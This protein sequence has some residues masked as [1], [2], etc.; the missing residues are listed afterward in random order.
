MFLSRLFGKQTPAPTNAVRGTVEIGIAAQSDPS[1]PEMRIVVGMAT[2][3]GC[4]REINED[5]VDVIRPDSAEALRDIGVVAV[6]CDG[7]GGHEGG[8]V[9]SRLAIEAF[10]RQVTSGPMSP[11]DMLI[12]AISA[13]NTA[14]ISAARR[15]P[16]LTGMG[17]TC[18]A[19]LLREGLAHC[20]HVGDSR[21]YMVR[22]GNIFLMTEDH[23][24]V[25]ELVRRGAITLEE[26]RHHPDKNVISRALGSQPNVQVSSW[27]RPLQVRPGDRFL[28]CS[29]GLHDLMSDG[30]ICAAVTANA[31]QEAC[32]RLVALARER[33]GYDN[34][35]VAILAM[36]DLPPARPKTPK[37]TR[38][39][40][41]LP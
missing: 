28:V 30:D 15:E 12:G 14:V 37:E 11:T 23:S 22:D 8:E 25:M 40:E 41:V 38:T 7:M 16:R 3:T 20:A 19:L 35:S 13:A 17:T 33:G 18:T 2:D 1:S 39:V 27:P 5:A 26:A 6:V 10:S 9:A 32:D 21:C 4:V 34:I 24:A 29:D 36:G 31:P